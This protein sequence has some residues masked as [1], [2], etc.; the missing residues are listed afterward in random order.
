LLRQKIKSTIVIK[1]LSHDFI[2]YLIIFLFCWAEREQWKRDFRAVHAK[3]QSQQ[4]IL[5]SDQA[6][7]VPN[8]QD[9]DDQLSGLI[10]P[11]GIVR[12]PQ[13]QERSMR[14]DSILARVQSQGGRT[15][16]IQREA[17]IIPQAQAPEAQIPSRVARIPAVVS[18]RPSLY[19]QQPDDPFLAAILRMAEPVPVR[20]APS[21][22]PKVPSTQV[23]LNRKVE[24]VISVYLYIFPSVPRSDPLLQETRSVELQ[25]LM[26]QHKFIKDLDADFPKK[27]ELLKDIS[28]KILA[29]PRDSFW[30]AQE[31]PICF[32][33]FE[34]DNQNCARLPCCSRYMHTACLFQILPNSSGNRTC[35]TCRA[36]L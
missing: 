36:V 7:G 4:R 19:A 16:A 21:S 33:G 25:N 28:Q 30:D 15:I 8:R 35:P 10:H 31:C 32:E 13:P 3:Q 24:Q 17:A 22:P 18:P 27:A 14:V 6:A 9:L 2:L 23:F 20:A 34:P 29:S 11:P 12:Q 26:A 5:S 1:L